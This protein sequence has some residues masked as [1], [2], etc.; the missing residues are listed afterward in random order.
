MLRAFEERK[1]WP[2]A[3]IAFFFD[4]MLAMLYLGRG[5]LGIAYLV[6]EVAILIGFR[7]MDGPNGG[8]IA[9]WLFLF[10]RVAGTAHAAMIARGGAQHYQT[11]WYARWYALV[12]IA[13]LPLIAAI[14]LRTFVFQLFD[15]RSTAM[16]PNLMIGD[17]L[18]VSKSAY[19]FAEPERGDVVVLRWKDHDYVKRIAGLP[20]DRIQMTSGVLG[21][22]DK[23]VVLLRLGTVVVAADSGE[24]ET[25]T[26]YRE[27]LPDGR[28]YTVAN[29]AE[30][31]PFDNTDVFTVPPGRYFV[32][33]DNR[34]ES[35][36]SRADL[37]YIPRAAIEGQVW[38]KYWN[39]RTHRLVW[40]S[41]P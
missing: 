41:V 24:P 3:L 12:S 30:D 7:G 28:S 9:S 29:Q 32:L 40:S 10:L 19:R 31:G 26:L 8:A 23:D 4:P 11:R 36:D 16:A 27:T 33:G 1:P 21:I 37:G 18:I 15:I 17:Y 13:V 25:L 14:A 35:N 2:A 39:G 5:W 22:N 6:V 20:G 38:R 34:D